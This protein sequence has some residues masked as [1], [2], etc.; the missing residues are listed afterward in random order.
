[1]KK[2]YL[3]ILS[4]FIL[5]QSFAQQISQEEALQY[6]KVGNTLREAQQYENA[7]SYLVGALKVIKGKNKYWEASA[8]E[9]L[10]LLYRDQHRSVEAV[11]YL[12]DAFLMYK[13]LKMK[14]SAMAVKTLLDGVEE[15][16]QLYAGIEIGAKG[17]KASVIGVY[18]NMDGEYKFKVK[19]DNSINPNVVTLT[20]EAIAKG[21]E[22]VNTFYKEIKSK[23]DL[24]DERIFIVGSSGVRMEAMNQNKLDKLEKAF[25]EQLK[26]GKSKLKF[27]TPEE[28]AY[29]VIKGTTLPKYRAVSSTID[30]G[31]G[32]TKGGFLIGENLDKIQPVSFPFGTKTLS[33]MI[34]ASMK[35]YQIG[36]DSA[37]K[38][39]A[40]K[41]V[42]KELKEQYDKNRGLKTRSVVHLVG[43]V[44][45]AMTTYL[46]PHHAEEAFVPISAVSIHKFRQEIMKNYSIITN[47]N[48]D[49]IDDKALK[50]KAEADILKVKENFSREELIAGSIILDE[51]VTQYNTEG[52]K[53]KFVFA[54]L[55]YVGWISGYI[56]EAVKKEYD[57]ME[58]L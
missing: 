22:A 12:T 52:P 20:D 31:S 36:Y 48:L 37:A 16:E 21:A 26:I 51:I 43:G 33:E 25:G 2:I 55:G 13:K 5:A 54:R 50:A 35:E 30:I 38:L 23:Y 1:M 6:I 10:G 8:Y 49:P 17:V 34:Q 3:L 56:M 41:Y 24:P 7:E 46:Y 57:S 11:K 27:I 42:R 19:Y 4:S 39:L 29:F 53:K 28:E 44:A 9:N 32:N 47:P 15:K 58:E 18:L 40:K 45:W 14:T